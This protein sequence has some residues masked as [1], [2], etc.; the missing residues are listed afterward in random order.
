MNTQGTFVVTEVARVIINQ[1]LQSLGIY[2]NLE[3][4]LDNVI[5][6]LEVKC[7]KIFQ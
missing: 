3:S 4:V 6:I 5:P 1:I 2:Y 7:F